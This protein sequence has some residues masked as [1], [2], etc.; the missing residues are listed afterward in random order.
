MWRGVLVGNLL[1]RAAAHGAIALATTLLAACGASD[2]YP[3]QQTSAFDRVASATS[4]AA[5]STAAGGLPSSGG[6]SS[7]SAEPCALVTKDEAATA[8]GKPGTN[9][10][11][12]G[13]GRTTGNAGTTVCQFLVQDAASVAQLSVIATKTPD[14]STTKLAFTSAKSG[15]KDSHPE[16]VSGVGD[17]AYWLPASKQLHVLSGRTYLILSGDAPVDAMKQVASA[18]VSRL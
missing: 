13:S 2:D 14:A 1:R 16:D 12:S 17:Q 9:M 18:A 4:T 15:A 3:G 6:N 10:Q 5:S 7:E 11:A 8:L